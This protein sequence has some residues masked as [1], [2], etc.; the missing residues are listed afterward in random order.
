MKS[1]E[2]IRNDLNTDVDIGDKYLRIFTRS[3]L[4]W[5]QYTIWKKAKKKRKK[6]YTYKYIY[7]NKVKSTI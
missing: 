7:I 1:L 6:N 4:K 5:K 3:T 2:S